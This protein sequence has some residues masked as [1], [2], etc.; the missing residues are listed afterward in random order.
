MAYQIVNQIEEDTWRAF[1]GQHPQGNIF[2]TP[3]MFEVFRQ[4]QGYQPEL[5]AAVGEKGQPLVLF[6]PVR[7][8][9]KSGWMK[10]LTTR[11]I[12]F[13]GVLTADTPE[14]G[15]ALRQVLRAYQKDSGRKSLFSEIRNVTACPGQQPELQS[16]GF[17]YEDHLNYLIN[18]DHSPET[19]F[20][21]IGKRTQ[22]NI[23]HGLNQGH[24]QIAEAATLKEVESG[25]RLLKKTYQA[26]QVPLA[27]FSLF[28]TAFDLLAPKGMCMVTLAQVKDQPAAASFEL[29]YKDTVYG[30]YGG[31]DRA[32]GSFVPNELLMWHI[33]RWGSEHSYACYDFGG[34]GKP[35]EEYGVR[36]FKSKFGGELV[37]F[38]RNTWVP[39][40]GLLAVSRM[41]YQLLRRSL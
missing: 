24:V 14:A 11:A 38:G 5:W 33:L 26:A 27:D 6:L 18:L 10:G 39:R 36:D 23:R 28:A 35:N 1:V 2:H 40:P 22:R 31:M 25:Y 34:A 15:D 29:L 21:G 12:V 9:L 30:W 7:I 17:I 37:C 32:F 4:T 41:G 16:A 19:V 3:E 20:K 8:S 13:G